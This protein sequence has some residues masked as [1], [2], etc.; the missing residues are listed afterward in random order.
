MI[1]RCQS[2]LLRAFTAAILAAALATEAS[3]QG[4][5][6]AR[7]ESVGISGARLNR[8][9]AAMQRAVDDQVLAGAVTLVARRGKIV[10]FESHGKLDR[11]RNVAMRNDAIF[12]IASMTKVVT[13][14]AALMLMEEGRLL[15]S[16]P[17]SKFIPSF[18]RTRVASSGQGEPVPARRPITIRDLMTHTAGISY[19]SG[20]LETLY[21]ENDIYFW[22]FAD[23]DEPIGV[24]IDRLAS[25]PFEAQPG[26]RY[27]YGFATDV[28]GVVVEKVSGL[29][30]DEYFRTRIFLPL[31]MTDTSFYLP[32]EKASRLAAVYS[33]GPDGLTRAP[34]AGRGQG[35]YVDGP[36][37]SFSGGAGLLSTA[38]DYVRFLQMLLNG[39]ELDGVRLVGPKTVELMTSNHVAGMYNGG[40]TGFGLG[41][42]VVEHVGRSGRP[43]SAGAFGWNGAYYTSMWVDPAEQLVAVFMSQLI[44]I[45]SATAQ[46]QFRALVYQSIVESE[47]RRCQLRAC[48]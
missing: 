47:T 27:V 31:K 4:L 2:F 48:N 37:K 11:E 36:R 39:G 35:G 13:S 24:S 23:K 1:D 14:V 7:P 26:E 12:R 42:E 22:Y 19:G 32:R 30:L 38:A 43:G 5:P 33:A 15:L 44:P 28:L 16:D 40:R 34:D 6:A 41:V 18:A 17:V 3:A 46:G 25:L 29:P 8:L 21:K 20:T 45:G 9:S 10:H